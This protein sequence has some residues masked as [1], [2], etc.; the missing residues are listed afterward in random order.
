MA[1]NVLQGLRAFHLQQRNLKSHTRIFAEAAETKDETQEADAAEFVFTTQGEGPMA[2][3]ATAFTTENEEPM[4]PSALAAAS[5]V[6]MVWDSGCTSHMVKDDALFS[7][8]GP[9][10]PPIKVT[11]ADGSYMMAYGRGT[12]RLRVRYKGSD[13][14]RMA[15]I[16][17][18]DGGVGATT[19]ATFTK[20]L[21]VPGLTRNLLS[22][23]AI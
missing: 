1:G 15:T 17:G 11:M 8:L 20:V 4:A 13:I 22:M 2:P 5:S 19:V 21:Y 10:D 18:P 16:Y 9:L 23:K 12:V 3:S 14:A 7:E 6:S